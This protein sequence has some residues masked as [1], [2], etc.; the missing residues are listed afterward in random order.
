MSNMKTYAIPNLAVSGSGVFQCDPVKLSQQA[1]KVPT[2]GDKTKYRAWCLDPATKHAFISFVEG[3]LPGSR[4]SSTNPARMVHGLVAEYDAKSS[5][6]DVEKAL[7]KCSEGRKPAAWCHSFSGNVRLFYPFADP[8]PADNQLLVDKFLKLLCAELKLNKLLPSFEPAETLNLN[9]Y[10]ELGK[11]WHEVPTGGLLAASWLQGLRVKAWEGVAGSKLNPDGVSIP[12]EVVSAEV[13]KRWPQ[14]KTAGFVEPG[15]RCSRFW[16]PT[17]DNP[18]ACIVRE[19]GITCFTGDKAFVSWADLLGVDWV[20]KQSQE[21]IGGATEGIYYNMAT[22]SYTKF[23][24]GVGWCYYPGHDIADDLT[25]AGL[26]AKAPPGGVSE[27]KRALSYIRNE[28]QIHAQLPFIYND[29]MIVEA[30]GKRYLNIARVK[31]LPPA[32]WSPQ[33]DGDRPEWGDGFPFTAQYLEW[34]FKGQGGDE[35][36]PEQLEWVLHWMRHAYKGA[37]EG[38]LER[39]LGLYLVGPSDAGK[40]VFCQLFMGRLMGGHEDCESMISGRDGFTGEKFAVG[41]WTVDDAVQDATHEGRQKV[42]QFIKKVIANKGIVDRGMYREGITRTWN[43]RVTVTMNDTETDLRMLPSASISMLDKVG[44]LKAFETKRHIFEKF[45]GWADDEQLDQE[46]PWLARWLLDGLEVDPAIWDRSRFGIKPFHHPKLV[47][48]AHQTD[49]SGEFR[50]L[51]QTYFR[52]LRVDQPGLE[53]WEG[54][55]TELMLELKAS[56]G[57]E[58]AAKDYNRTWIGRLLGDLEKQERSGIGRPERSSDKRSWLIE[59]DMLLRDE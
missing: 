41:L 34:M 18:T 50:E 16:D 37:L 27:V 2:H 53:T 12:F 31:A 46:L 5:A 36:G 6:E 39:G 4:V 52:M 49:K 23:K 20:R 35:R 8:V 29:N 57:V 22:R 40:S 54:S 15:S 19:N 24:E 59:L 14:A 10:Y 3:V 43:G 33:H 30:K 48:K 17:A 55:A 11:A 32:E 51:L 9:Q 47:Q 45:G 28:Q 7:A 26:D 56:P 13:E 42:S 58:A 44:I 38:N 25:I 1:S 21:K